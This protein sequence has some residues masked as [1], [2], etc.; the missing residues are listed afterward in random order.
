MITRS[1]QVK[2]RPSNLRAVQSWAELGPASTRRRSVRAPAK[3]GRSMSRRWRCLRGCCRG[4]DPAARKVPLSST[5]VR[6]AIGL[7]VA[8]SAVLAL[9]WSPMRRSRP[10]GRSNPAGR[11]PSG[12]A[13]RRR[14]RA[15]RSRRPSRPPRTGLGRRSAHPKGR[16]CPKGRTLPS[17]PSRSVPP[18]RRQLGRRLL[19]GSHLPW[20]VIAAI[21]RLQSNH[22][23]F[24]GSPTRFTAAGD[25]AP[26]VLGPALDGRPGFA[27]IRDTD[28]APRTATGSGTAPL[29][30]CSS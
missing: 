7:A 4:T 26:E 24:K 13:S 23:R 15:P 2:R 17:S 25:V 30:R 5:T 14:S 27:A 6:Q 10:T 12:T 20:S 22:G 9:S 3:V 16:S 8:L 19:P 18:E 29:V 21:G 1:P 11:R 28:A